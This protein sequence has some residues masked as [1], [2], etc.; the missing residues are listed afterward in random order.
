MTR[1]GFQ[2]VTVGKHS[3]YNTREAIKIEDVIR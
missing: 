1:D 3:G 2:E